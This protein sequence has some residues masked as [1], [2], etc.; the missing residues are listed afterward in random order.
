MCTD[1][2]ARSYE[3]GK[4]KTHAY[5]EVADAFNYWRYEEFI[6]IYSYASGPADGQR[7]FLRASILG[8]LNR[9]IANG[10][11]ATGGYK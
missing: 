10:L 11:N 6:K 2:W 5:E 3:N 1:L 8:D 7:Q 4:L 9:F